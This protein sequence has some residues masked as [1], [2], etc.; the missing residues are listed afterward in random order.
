MLKFNYSQ[1]LDE[2]REKAKNL[3]KRKQQE[4]QNEKIERNI[5]GR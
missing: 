5:I 1:K 2:F 4:Y 3:L